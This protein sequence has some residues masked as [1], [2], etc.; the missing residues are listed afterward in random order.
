MLQIS[1]AMAEFERALIAERVRAGVPCPK[2]R[3]NAIGRPRQP[4]DAGK[5][6]ELRAQGCSWAKIA[7]EMGLGL[8]TVHRASTIALS[9]YD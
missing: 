3:A 2:L 4:V 6:A 7:Q 9:R 8:G 5:V 1:G